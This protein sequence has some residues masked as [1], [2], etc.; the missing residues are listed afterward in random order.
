MLNYEDE[1]SGSFFFK[2]NGGVCNSVLD[3]ENSF[4][5]RFSAESR[6][7]LRPERSRCMKLSGRGALSRCWSRA[8]R[9]RLRTLQC[10]LHTVKNINLNKPR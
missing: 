6:R 10:A 5:I 1:F 9:A 2:L 7:A 3:D 8:D 4:L